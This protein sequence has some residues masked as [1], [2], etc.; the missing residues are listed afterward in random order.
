MA[1]CGLPRMQQALERA[2]QQRADSHQ[3]QGA[4]SASI[5]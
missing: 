4:R 3:V 2:W 5:E 1:R